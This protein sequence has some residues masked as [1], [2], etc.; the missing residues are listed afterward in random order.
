MAI[1]LPMFVYY[2][3]DFEK[4]GH[5]N[6][7][8]GSYGTPPATGFINETTFCYEVR[9]EKEEDGLKLVAEYWYRNP[10]TAAEPVTPGKKAE[11]EAS[12]K[13]VKDA[14]EW[15]NKATA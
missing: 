12:D 3:G 11:F 5:V 2:Y 8:K 13:G 14:E 4:S 15:L 7:Y 9:L 10:W 6:S 1:K